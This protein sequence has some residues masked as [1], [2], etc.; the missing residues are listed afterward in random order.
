MRKGFSLWESQSKEVFDVDERPKYKMRFVGYDANG[1]LK[2]TAP[3]YKRNEI[4]ELPLEYAENPWWELIDAIPDLVIPEKRYE[5]SVFVEETFVPSEDKEKLILPIE[6][7]PE[8]ADVINYD[9]MTVKS[10]KLFIE[11]RGG[12]VDPKWLK[13]DLVRE[14]RELEESLREISKSS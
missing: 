5:D 1:E 11:M 9:G 13:V 3:T 2:P 6:V 7:T 8:D 12:E 4:R 14:A 10:L